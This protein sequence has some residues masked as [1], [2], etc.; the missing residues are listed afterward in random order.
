MPSSQQT[1]KITINVILLMITLPTVIFCGFYTGWFGADLAGMTHHDWSLA[2]LV[3][4][5]VGVIAALVFY[6]LTI[7]IL[8]LCK[9]IPLT[10]AIIAATVTALLLSPIAG[11]ITQGI[12]AA[13]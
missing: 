6:L 11:A 3:P 12:M 8:L 13:H 10:L 2:P 1:L 4:A 5:S 9:R 7:I